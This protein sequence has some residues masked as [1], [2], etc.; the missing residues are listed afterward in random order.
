[1]NRRLIALCTCLLASLSWG[2]SPPTQT[3]VPDFSPEQKIRAIY[4]NMTYSSKPKVEF[5]VSNFET[6]SFSDF[7]KENW[8]TKISLVQAPNEQLNFGINIKQR[9]FNGKE[10]ST[11]VTY[12][13]RWSPS[14]FN[15]YPIA[16]QIR[17]VSVGDYLRKWYPNLALAA[18]TVVTYSVRV[19]DATHLQTYNAAC[20]I[21]LPNNYRPLD[22]V[23]N[24]P[25]VVDEAVRCNERG[26][27]KK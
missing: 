19:Q 17:N 13:P 14:A 3:D 11:T 27:D 9:Q 8:A 20:L 2:Q 12:L 26:C 24:I 22:P 18:N 5:T 7:L 21:T 6:E 25:E 1:M 4:D 16:N 23:V 10:T 15:D